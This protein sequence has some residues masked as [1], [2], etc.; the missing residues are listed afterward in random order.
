M[1]LLGLKFAHERKMFF[2]KTVAAYK[3]T[4]VHISRY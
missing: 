1:N 4:V 2:S 3:Q